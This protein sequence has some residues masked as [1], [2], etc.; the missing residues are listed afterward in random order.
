MPSPLGIIYPSNQRYPT[1]WSYR[2]LKLISQRNS[3]ICVDQW[4][5]PWRTGVPRT[6][7][8]MAAKAG[9]SAT[10]WWEVSSSSPQ[11]L[12]KGSSS[13]W[14]ITLCLCRKLWPV[15]NCTASLNSFLPFLR[16]SKE[17]NLQMVG[18][19]CLV[20]RQSMRDCQHSFHLRSSPSRWRDLMTLGGI[21]GICAASRRGSKAPS[22]ASTS[23]RSLPMMPQWPFTY[24]RWMTLFHAAWLRAATVSGFS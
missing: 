6:L 5:V 9:H 11:L 19:H 10:T 2:E 18:N 17:I 13:S 22:F 8:R 12:H 3:A 1:L 4:S 14:T 20:W 15:I 16:S 21:F 24:L 23:A 7:S